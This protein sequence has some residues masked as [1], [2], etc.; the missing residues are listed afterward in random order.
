MTTKTRGCAHTTTATA[1]PSCLMADMNEHLRANGIDPTRYNGR[2][3]ED[4]TERA[5]PRNPNPG[6]ITPGRPGT[7]NVTALD[8]RRMLDQRPRAGRL[9]WALIADLMKLDDE[10][11]TAAR[12]W[13]DRNEQ[14]LT[15]GQCSTWIHRLRAKIAT[16]NGQPIVTTTAPTGVVTTA[17]ARPATGASAELVSLLAGLHEPVDAHPD[18]GMILRRYALDGFETG[19]EV[20]F[21][22]LR[23]SKRGR[24]YLVA[25]VSDEERM[26][27]WAEA[28]IVARRITADPMAAM[29]RYGTE[30]GSCGHCGRTLT[31][32]ESRALGIGPKCR[33]GFGI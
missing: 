6:M 16:Y 3:G 28:L 10:A 31:N 30:L 23:E 15:V 12:N 8:D 17:P 20:R 26:V 21:Y 1:C 27:P 24:R 5:M 18:R 14:T 25:Q 33:Q 32:D 19:N 2:N 13:M 11:G 22:K 7:T 4:I 9:A 29:L